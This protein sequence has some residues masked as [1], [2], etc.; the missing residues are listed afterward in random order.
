MD[1]NAQYWFAPYWENDNTV[2]PT[3]VQVLDSEDEW[4]NVRLPYGQGERQV[5][6]HHLGVIRC[7]S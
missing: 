1:A 6:L 3:I 7:A 4:Y 2:N 5:H